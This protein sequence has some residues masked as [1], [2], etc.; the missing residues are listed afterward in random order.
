MARSKPHTFLT[1][2]FNCFKTLQLLYRETVFQTRRLLMLLLCDYV[3]Y[4]IVTMLFYYVRERMLAFAAAGVAG[5]EF[6][7]LRLA[8]LAG[9]KMRLTLW[10]SLEGVRGI[11]DQIVCGWAVKYSGCLLRLVRVNIKYSILEN[12]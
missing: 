3:H 4:V 5:L 2:R 8:D 6:A 1:K 11:A 10:R 12:R 9:R 7:G